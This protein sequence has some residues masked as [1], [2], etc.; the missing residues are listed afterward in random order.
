MATAAAPNPTEV[1]ARLRR[2]RAAASRVAVCA[3]CE[4]VLKDEETGAPVRLAPMHRE[5]HQLIDKHPRL[6]LLAHLESAKTSQISIARVLW[7]VGRNT[8]LRVA[9]ISNTHGQAVKIGRS[10]AGYIET[11]PEL[12][13][14]FQGLR[15]DPRGPWNETEMTVVRP[16]V[17]KDPSIQC[18]GVHGN[19]LGARLDLVV[20]D[21]IADYESTRTE[22]QRKDLVAW[23]DATV[24]GRLTARARVW[25]VGTAW[26]LEDPLH[27]FQARGW[28]TFKYPVELEDG[29]PRWPERWPRERID[30]KRLELGPAESGRQLDVEVR[31]DESATIKLEWVERAITKGEKA[32]RLSY[33]DKGKPYLLNVSPAYRVVL[34]VDLAVSKK[35]TADLS[36][37]VSLLVHPDGTREVL[38]VESGRWHG[39][40]ITNHIADAYVRFGASTV[41]VESNAAQAYIS[42]FL[43]ALS[44]VPVVPFVTGRGEASLQWRVERIATE[45]ARGQWSLPSSNGKIRDKETALLARD[46]LHY[47]PAGRHTADRISAAAMAQYGCETTEVRGEY[48][49]VNWMNR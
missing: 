24:L 26:H 33:T 49:Y 31:D 25:A 39:D 44:H 45:L 14:V 40:E 9:I 10:I 23:L 5:W 4:Y 2:Q 12:H 35:V 22:A 3:F 34:G 48:G 46:L 42:H 13:A 32:V 21:D 29:S 1:L 8:A 43:Q 15:P 17:M 27:V 20:L 47:S 38:S 41:V 19:I 11:S 7:E 28:P 37:I 36:V 18:A 16:H 30:A 6:A